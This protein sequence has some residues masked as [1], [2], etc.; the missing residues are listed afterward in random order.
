MQV[1][2]ADIGMGNAAEIAAAGI[3]AIRSGDLDFDLSG[4]RSCDSS[5]VA[6][7]LAWKREAQSLGKPLRLSAVPDCMLSLAKVY[8]VDPLLV[9]GPT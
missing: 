7:L 1:A 4:V 2:A 6:V 3:E 5:A 9:S 8:G